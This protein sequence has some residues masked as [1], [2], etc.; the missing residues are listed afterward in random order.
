MSSHAEADA[1]EDAQH[2]AMLRDML[3]VQA[4]YSAQAHDQSH[5]RR[6]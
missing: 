4:H 3:H 2:V 5:A 6:G 1:A